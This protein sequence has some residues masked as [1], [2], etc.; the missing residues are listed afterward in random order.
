[1]QMVGYD[2][3]MLMCYAVE[4]VLYHMVLLLASRIALWL[5]DE[6]HANSYYCVWCDM[7]TDRLLKL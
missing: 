7:D 5:I 4:A 2:L 3:A 1:M 6:W